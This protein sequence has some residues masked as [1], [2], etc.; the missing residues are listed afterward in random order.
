MKELLRNGLGMRNALRGAGRLG[1][2]SLLG[3]VLLACIL[4]SEI[5]MLPAGLEWASRV[6]YRCAFFVIL[7]FR[8]LVAAVIPRVDHHWPLVHFIASCLG[9]PFFLW[10]CWRLSRSLYRRASARRQ[11]TQSSPSSSGRA[12]MARRQF[13]SRSA[14]GAV[15]L[16]TGGITGYASFVEPSR[17]KVRNYEVHIRGLPQELEGMRL[18]HV[19]DTHYGPYTSITFV[20]KAIEQANELQGDVVILTG[21]YVHFTPQSIE[22]GIEVLGQLRSRFG[23]VA[24]MGNH[25]HW[26]GAEACRRVF[27]R[28][29]IPLLDNTRLFLTPEGLRDGPVPGKSLCLA[30]VGDLWEDEVSFEKALGGVP[31]DMPRVVLSHNPDTAELIR[32]GQRID[33]LL[34]GHTHGGQVRLPVVGPPFVPTRHGKKYLGGMCHGPHCPVLVSRGIGLAGVPARFRVPPEVGLV[35]LRRDSDPMDVRESG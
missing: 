5:L 29:G 33:L 22:R 27:E 13:L 26:E 8:V 34:C 2:L 9:T 10:G 30:G 16:A 6:F 20:E 17:V 1:G 21:D 18:V 23:S 14:A 3:C 31:G 15:S 19:S 11:Q 7:P 35:V 32:R 24:V 4:H 28:V 25:E 12:V